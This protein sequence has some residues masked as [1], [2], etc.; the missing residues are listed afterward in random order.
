MDKIVSS[1]HLKDRELYFLIYQLVKWS[2]GY[3]GLRI[4]D[5][6]LKII[7]YE[8]RIQINFAIVLRTLTLRAG[9]QFRNSQFEII[10]CTTW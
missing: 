2:E 3:L 4:S 7:N 1:S 10:I 6:G 8:L 5:F 9:S